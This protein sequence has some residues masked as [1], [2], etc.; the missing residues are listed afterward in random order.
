MAAFY[1]TAHT[2]SWHGGSRGLNIPL[3]LVRLSF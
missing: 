2:I 3:R 1:R